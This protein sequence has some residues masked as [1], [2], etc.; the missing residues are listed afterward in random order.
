MRTPWS[1]RAS[2]W[3]WGRQRRRRPMP[4]LWVEA[5]L[6]TLDRV[7]EGMG[8]CLVPTESHP[9]IDATDEDAWHIYGVVGE[10]WVYLGACTGRMCDA[11][12][13]AIQ[14]AE[15]SKEGG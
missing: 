8:L 15:H 5:D 3:R 1:G 4:S 6:N 11:I 12:D 13:M 10:G 7:S 9:P 14:E 2:T